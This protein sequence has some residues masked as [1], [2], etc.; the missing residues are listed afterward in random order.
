MSKNLIP[1][2]KDCNLLSVRPLLAL[3]LLFSF[4]FL[5]AQTF[6]ATI[7]P[8]DITCYG[9]ND[10]T[11][12]VE[13]TGGIGPFEVE[14]IG[15]DVTDL[16]IT[17]L[18]AGIVACTVTDLGDGS[19]VFKQQI[20]TEPDEFSATLGS[21]QALSSASA[22][23]ASVSVIV[24][25]GTA[26]FMADWP[27]AASADGLS[28][29]NICEDYLLITVTDGSGCTTQ[30]EVDLSAPENETGDMTVDIQTSDVL[31][32]GF[33]NGSAT[34]S[35]SGVGPY[36]I[37][38]L[39]GTF[40]GIVETYSAGDIEFEKTGLEAGT[41]NITVTDQGS[42]Q[43]ENYQVVVGSP[44]VLIAYVPASV[45]PSSCNSCDGSV[46]LVIEGGTAPFDISLPEGAVL[47]ADG[48]SIS[49]LCAGSHVILVTDSNNCYSSASLALD[50]NADSSDSTEEEIVYEDINAQIVKSNLTCPGSDDGFAQLLNVTGGSGS[51]TYEWSDN[52]STSDSAS[53]YAPGD[54][55]VT[56]TDDQGNTSTQ[57]FEITDA[58]FS[59]SVVTTN[60]LSG[61]CN[62]SAAFDELIGGVPPFEMEEFAYDFNALCPGDYHF[63]VIDGNGC[64]ATAEFT[65][66]E[67]L[68]EELP[69]VGPVQED[70]IWTLAGELGNYE[71]LYDAMKIWVVAKSMNFSAGQAYKIYSATGSLVQEGRLNERS[72]EIET[73]N[74]ERGI[75]IIQTETDVIR[76]ATP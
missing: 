47:S 15:S 72:T 20:I 24:I 44:E 65:I 73:S 23:D 28:A 66:E 49:G 53:G 8:T 22:C 34:I 31:C 62:G 35:I 50:C 6:N 13:I 71:L 76:F 74:L 45:M 32:A 41:H 64:V 27:S 21:V 60:S 61:Q 69:S 37:S 14:W 56:I 30:V 2:F 42:G 75:Y 36:E 4:S 59:V 33:N 10:G 16:T 48:Q 11:A 63:S 55:S 17:G 26:P 51:Y 40:S 57:E 46:E 58:N 70:D 12:T 39:D 7:V 25:G 38:W 1:L 19:N 18:S 68:P 67:I 5:N 9:A 43:T 52:A 29:S 54:Y 3:I